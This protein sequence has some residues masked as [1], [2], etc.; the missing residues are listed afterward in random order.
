M[1][2]EDCWVIAVALMIVVAAVLVAL[3]SSGKLGALL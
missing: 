3:W 2:I 1:R